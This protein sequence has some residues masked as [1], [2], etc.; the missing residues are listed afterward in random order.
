MPSSYGDILSFIYSNVTSFEK[1]HTLCMGD[2]GVHRIFGVD[3]VAKSFGIDFIVKIKQRDGECDHLISYP[4]RTA[5]YGSCTSC[6][7]RN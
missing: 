1:R 2:W 5:A 7:T 6:Q 3:L 4:R